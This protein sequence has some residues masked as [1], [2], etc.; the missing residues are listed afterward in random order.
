MNPKNRNLVI[1]IVLVCA[2]VIS[3][4]G[5][6]EFVSTESTGSSRTS[7][8][9]SLSSSPQPSPQIST[10][11]SPRPSPSPSPS[12]TSSP[13]PAEYQAQCQKDFDEAKTFDEETR[14]ITLPNVNLVIVN[15]TWAIQT[16]GESS[17]SADL[18]DINRT[19]KIYKG[20]FIM[21]END[22]LYQA[23]VDWAGYFISA[24]WNG[25]IYVITEN[26][27]PW[28]ADASATFAHEL[29]HIM[30]GLYYN[31][32]NYPYTSTFDGSRARTALIEGD[33]NYMESLY[34]NATSLQN[35]TSPSPSA[36]PTL[37]WAL[38]ENL[39]Y[40]SI[41]PSIP[42]SVSDFDY[43]PYTYGPDFIAALYNSGG[44]TLVDQ[45]YSNPPNT[46]QQILLP[47][48]YFR[49]VDAQ[50]VQPPVLSESGWEQVKTDT[51]G[52]YFIQVMLSNWISQDTA[53]TVAASWCGDKLN[54]YE[55][56]NDYLFTWK[57]QWNSTSSASAFDSA[58][59]SLMKA[60][61][62][63]A[64]N[65]NEWFANGRYLS[66]QWSSGSNSTVI[67]CSTN[68]TSALQPIT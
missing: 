40:S 42:N 51:Y 50:Q 37:P 53:Q 1:A 13:S 14:N 49:G 11:P 58:F 55:R 29:T 34:Q 41:Q 48:T 15:Q 47:E 21:P 38:V 66:L 54:Y 30:Q 65:T 45:A 31:I 32:P 4:F 67:V 25:Q 68:E 59:Q 64:E 57:I 16:W 62:A 22:S 12:P 10:T 5:V 35:S 61:G 52:Q 23:T 18:V 6:R 60:T 20:L 33:A 56:G 24:V 9:P 17:A 44:W 7:P 26:F 3:G 39:G 28:S 8:S 2:L 36:E 43:F 27:N 19:E 63:T 46:T